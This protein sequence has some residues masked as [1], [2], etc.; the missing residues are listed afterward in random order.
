[1]FLFSKLLFQN[2]AAVSKQLVS[3]LHRNAHRDTTQ[4]QTRSCSLLEQNK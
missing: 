3:F 4:A 2:A 1:M